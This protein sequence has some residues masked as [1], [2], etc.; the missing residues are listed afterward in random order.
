MGGCSLRAGHPNA[1]KKDEVED[2]ESRPH[3]FGLGTPGEVSVSIP[4]T[5]ILSKRIHAQC[6]G[7]SPK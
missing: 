5:I 3:H 1:Q 2:M 7:I 6:G 4:S